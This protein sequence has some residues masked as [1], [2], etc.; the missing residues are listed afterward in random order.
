MA[1]ITKI[2]RPA[3]PVY[4]ARIRPDGRPELSRTFKNR[5]DAAKWAR[6]REVERDR[7]DS[8]LVS[9]GQKHTLAE[10]IARYREEV[11][12]EL[13][14]ETARKY[15]QHLEH[16]APRLGHLRLSEVTPQKIAA[17]RDELAADERAPATRNRYLATIA[18]VLTACVKRWHW[19]ASSPMQG[20]AKP[21]EANGGTRFLSD[22]ELE[23][24]LTACRAS[25]SPDLLVAVMLSITTGARQGEILGLRWRDVDL[26]AGILRL[27]VDAETTTKGGI[28]TLPIAPQ[29]VSLL[30]AR[31]ETRRASKV[32]PL[33][34]DGYVF[35]SR[36]TNSKPVTLRRPW[37]TA[38][39][40]AGIEG[41]RWHDLRHSAASFL[42]KGGASLL[43]IGAVLGH[44][45]ANTTR[46]YAHLTEQHTNDLVLSLA[47]K[48]LG[49]SN[50]P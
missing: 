50:E 35:P 12:P 27:R 21:T 6:A 40:R 45:S 31:R 46:R 43:E 19:L 28:R 37:E 15:A 26:D 44:K 20:V 29:A 33:R 36:V 16:W 39:H 48:L 9:E 23:R 7:D 4:K 49:A 14:P 8:G 42:A 5:S 38:L 32:T 25:V 18:S 30:L 22:D 47:D 34:D 41:F 3:G 1:T 24:L 10:A 13:R 2:N 11:L 17:V